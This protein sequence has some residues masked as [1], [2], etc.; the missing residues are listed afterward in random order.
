MEQ[1][2]TGNFEIKLSPQ[3]DE[4]NRDPFLGRL[5][6]EKDFSGD[7]EGES[8]GQMLS[9]RTATENSAG[10]VAM[11]K[12][13]GRIK[14]LEGSIILQHSGIINR[15]QSKLDLTIVPD[16]GSG[17]LLG[18]SGS[19]EIVIEGKNHSYKLSYRLP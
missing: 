2:A 12:F 10:Y 11:E 4:S 19:M 17:Q 5:L 15:G 6:I 13:S 7:M 8:F 1:I 3:T 18:I 16:S 9:A 14:G